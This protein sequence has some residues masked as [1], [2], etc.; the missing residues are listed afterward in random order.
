MQYTVPAWLVGMSQPQLQA[1]L[2]SLQTAYAAI[3][4]GRREVIVTY[5]QGEGTKSVTFNQVS[6]TSLR[7]HITEVQA[8]LGLGQPRRALRPT[9]T[10]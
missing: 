7:Q 3:I 1:L 6:A 8:A 10:R 2:A 5:G 9:W 4:T